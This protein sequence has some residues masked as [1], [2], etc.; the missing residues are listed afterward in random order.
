M[1][2]RQRA[3]GSRNS[4]YLRQSPVSAG[5][6]PVNYY[7]LAAFAS[8]SVF[9]IVW[10][11]LH[12]GID[13]TPLIA[14][15]I[16]AASFSIS[17]IFV[18]EVIFRRARRRALAA[19]ML[20]RQLRFVNNHHDRDISGPKLSLKRN[21]ELLQEIRAKSEAAKVLGKF[22]DAHKEVFDLCEDYLRLVAAE[23][24]AA[25]PTSPR[26][27][28]MKKG[29][30][31]AAGRHRFHMLKWAEIKARSFTAEAGNPGSI[32]DKI[33]AGADAL[34]AVD[35]AIEAYPEEPTLTE[36]QEVLRIFVTSARAKLYINN[37]ERAAEQG[38][39]DDAVEHYQNALSCL[40]KFDVNFE[41][42]ALILDKI[43]LEISRIQQAR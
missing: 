4:P 40:S 28:A 3:I 34:G 23:L 35:R 36:S 21:E 38:S 11:A 9:F 22:A 32:E 2:Q 24:S 31:S 37:A 1:D 42:R 15:A 19:Q 33:S 41:E 43:N 13:D 18:R 10:A 8:A 16:A 17:F 6:N 5:L 29:S 20:S 26:I 14:A 25:R 12:D 30:K 27:P 7:L 39:N